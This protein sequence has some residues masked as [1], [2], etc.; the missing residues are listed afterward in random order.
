MAKSIEARK[1]ILRKRILGTYEQMGLL[2]KLFLYVMLIAIGFVYVFPL[3]SMLVMSFETLEDLLDSSV[4]WIPNTLCWDNYKKAFEVMEF[5]E[6]IQDTLLL[7]AVPAL[8]QTISCGLAGYG[9]ARF[10][11]KGK[12]VVMLLVLLTFIVPFPL[13]ML[14]TYMMYSD[15]GILGSAWTMLLPA[16]FGQ[17]LRSAIFILI[18]KAM[19]EQTPRSLDEAARVDGASEKRVFFTI[20]IPLGV[21]GMLTTFL[22]SFVWYWNETYTTSLYITNTGRN[23]NLSTLMMELD[24]FEAS[25]SAYLQNQYGGTA[26]G[27]AAA[28]SGNALNEAVT[29][30]GVMITILVPLLIYFCLQRYFVQAIDRSGITGE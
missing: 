10:N 25:Y 23:V 6:H 22:F 12:N 14:P 8:F 11:F 15:Y 29:M 28:S 17:G 24:R 26:V 9:L 13:I 4:K 3:L 1:A 2:P 20:G 19:F 27:A 7:T 18:F 21:S 16:L 30:A 5:T